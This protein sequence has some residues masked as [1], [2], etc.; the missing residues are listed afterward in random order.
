M[1]SLEMNYD[2]SPTALPAEKNYGE[3]EKEYPCL[4]ITQNVPDELFS[5]EIGDEVEIKAVVRINR[6]G[7]DNTPQGVRRTLDLEFKG[8][9]VPEG[10]KQTKTDKLVEK[11]SKIKGTK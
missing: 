1:K 5:K 4:Y 8:I 6:K 10:E 2:S 7:E 9:D 3:R 11:L